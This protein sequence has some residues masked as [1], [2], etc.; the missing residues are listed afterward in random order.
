[1]FCTLGRRRHLPMVCQSL[2]LALARHAALSAALELVAFLI[3]FR[4]VASHRPSGAPKPL[5][6]WIFLVIAATLGLL[7]SLSAQSGCVDSTGPSRSVTGLFAKNSTNATWLFR[8][9][10]FLVPMVW[11]FQFALASGIHGTQATAEFAARG[12]TRSEYDGGR[13]R[14]P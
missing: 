11:G 12:G 5:E 1:M 13:C 10:A 2:S 6:P 4:A 3:F 7:T 9:G 14:I 8:L